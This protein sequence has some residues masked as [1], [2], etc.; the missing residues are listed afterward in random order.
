MVTTKS[1][2][3]APSGASSKRPITVGDPK[4]APLK[5]VP[6]KRGKAKREQRRANGGGL[7]NA[8]K[9][10]AH[11]V[12]NAVEDA[13]GPVAAACAVVRWFRGPMGIPVC[14]DTGRHLLDHEAANGEE[15]ERPAGEP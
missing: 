10:V 8:V 3:G 4:T 13:G 5:K 15:V 2:G 7:A 14:A 6:K 11:V 12:R 9:D 1:K